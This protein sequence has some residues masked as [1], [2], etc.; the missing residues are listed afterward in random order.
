LFY[1]R[2]TL[3]VSTTSCHPQVSQFTHTST[4]LQRSHLHSGTC[5]SQALTILYSLALL[6]TQIST[7][8][9]SLKLNAS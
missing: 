5:I 7:E 4:K 3:H 1:F 8:L 6:A 2:I 9:H